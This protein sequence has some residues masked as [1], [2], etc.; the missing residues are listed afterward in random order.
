VPGL[1]LVLLGLRAL[2]VLTWNLETV[3]A[4]GSA[5]Y[6][7]A[8]DVLQRIG[9]DVVA[10]QEIATTTDAG[11]LLSLAS[12][13]QY[14]YA[15]VAPGGPFGSDRTAFMSDLPILTGTSWT[16]AQLSG[17]ATANDLTRYI[18]EVEIDVT[19]Q[20]DFMNAKVKRPR[21]HGLAE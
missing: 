16:A 19:G 4:K 13:L 15:T 17:D 6:N 18:L 11:H 2:R 3:G 14:N 20:A 8:L 5:E 21:W 12:D 7:A 10:V 1:I 9:A